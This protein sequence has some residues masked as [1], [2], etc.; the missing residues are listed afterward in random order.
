MALLCGN[1]ASKIIYYSDY[2][3]FIE[4][5]IIRPVRKLSSNSFHF[6]DG[7]YEYRFTRFSFKMSQI[8]LRIFGCILIFYHLF[9]EA[10]KVPI[11]P[12]LCESMVPVNLRNI[13]PQVSEC[14]YLLKVSHSHIRSGAHF[15]I[16]IKSNSPDDVFQD[17]MIQVRNENTSKP[18]GQFSSTP[19]A[20]WE[21][22]VPG[23]KV[24]S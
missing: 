3:F 16:T 12:E 8:I 22:C 24:S 6:K 14:P 18:F 17:F 2:R 19:N 23:K 7:I 10:W 1:T 9:C 21:Y 11:S 4:N 15:E 20:K 13:T 5:F